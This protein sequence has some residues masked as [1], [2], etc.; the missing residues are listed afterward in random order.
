MPRL[1]VIILTKNEE[2]NIEGAMESAAFADE[3]VIIDSGSTDRTKELA[4]RHGAKF[5]S[6]PMDDEGFAGQRNFA[7]TQTNAEWVLYLDADER[8]NDKLALEIKKHI[9]ECPQYAA[10]IK[11]VNVVM[12]QT[13]YHGVYRPDY[14]Q[15]LFKRENVRWESVVHEHAVTDMPTVCLKTPMKHLC[16]TNWHQYISKL[17]RY[18]TLMA[19]EMKLRGKKVGWLQMHSHAMFAFLKMYLLKGGFLDGKLGFILCQLHYF[20]TLMKYVKLHDLYKQE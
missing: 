17:D 19:E 13:M 8:L 2:A 14:C 3:I 6:H 11:R 9:A 10:E 4:E 16:L 1:A 12:G 20:Y 5:V 15:R 7:L 18:T